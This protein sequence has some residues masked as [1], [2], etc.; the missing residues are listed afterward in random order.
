MFDQENK[1][2]HLTAHN[3]KQLTADQ[4][5]QHVTATSVTI[6]EPN[7]GVLNTEHLPATQQQ[8]TNAATEASSVQDNAA[9]NSSLSPI[10]FPN[11]L[12]P[13]AAGH[14]FYPAKYKGLVVYGRLYDKQIYS[15]SISSTQKIV[16][17]AL[18]DFCQSDFA[19]KHDGYTN[20]A[21]WA[22]ANRL[23]N[24][25]TSKQISR[26]IS[27][28]KDEGFIEVEY[29]G[30][31]GRWIK[32]NVTEK[33]AERF[34]PV[35]NLE[36]CHLSPAEII[37]L[38]LTS[39]YACFYARGIDCFALPERNVISISRR[40][41][42]E[43]AF[44]KN[45]FNLALRN[46]IKQNLI[47]IEEREGAANRGYF[48]DKFYTERYSHLFRVWYSS[49]AHELILKIA[50]HTIM[51][52]VD[53][54]IVR[55][56]RA[57]K[58]GVIGSQLN[59]LDVLPASKGFV[60][61]LNDK[62]FM[63]EDGQVKPITENLPYYE[64]SLQQHYVPRN[65]ELYPL[66][67]TIAE[68]QI[69]LNI[70]RRDFYTLSPRD[71]WAI[72]LLDATRSQTLADQTISA[73]SYST[74]QLKSLLIFGISSRPYIGHGWQNMLKKQVEQEVREAKDVT[75]DVDTT[76]EEQILNDYYQ[77]IMA[78]DE[79]FSDD[80]YSGSV[81]NE[82]SSSHYHSPSEDL[83]TT[84][85]NTHD[86]ASSDHA[87]HHANHSCAPTRVYRTKKGEGVYTKKGPGSNKKGGGVEQKKGTNK[88]EGE[89]V[90]ENVSVKNARVLHNTESNHHEL[91]YDLIP[92]VAYDPK[93][94]KRPDLD[95]AAQGSSVD[96]A[97]TRVLNEYLSIMI[98][99]PALFSQYGKMHDLTPT[100][101]ES[102]MDNTNIVV[103]DHTK[104][105]RYI[106]TNDESIFSRFQKM[107]SL[108][109][110][111][112]ST[113]GEY[114][115]PP[116]KLDHLIKDRPL[117]KTSYSPKF[118]KTPDLTPATL[119]GTTGTANTTAL[120]RVEGHDNDTTIQP[121]FDPQRRDNL[122]LAAIYC[123]KYD[124][125]YVMTPINDNLAA[126][127]INEPSN[128]NDL[129]SIASAKE[130]K[131]RSLAFLNE[132][133]YRALQPSRDRSM[134]Y[135]LTTSGNDYIVTTHN[136]IFKKDTNQS[137]ITYV[138]YQYEPSIL[139][140]PYPSKAI[141]TLYKNNNRTVNFSIHFCYTTIKA[142]D[143][144]LG[145]ENY[146]DKSERKPVRAQT[147]KK[148]A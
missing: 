90:K 68:P 17:S 145:I 27:A 65:N 33:E 117:S 87:A 107:L 122:T 12:S 42:N 136:T 58:I 16:L 112:Q 46:L 92:A 56:M 72:T 127:T 9:S 69:C 103:L 64:S 142:E 131:H 89:N 148:N 60:I 18:N 34:T 51:S 19:S 53:T 75:S 78:M 48:F 23:N 10:G 119:G 40:L 109:A 93:N 139:K 45:S 124:I 30:E 14:N 91:E 113:K 132:D 50:D 26:H 57:H 11:S 143:N 36:D 140:E 1:S 101:Q 66:E 88:N 25:F 43:Q 38:S 129:L 47:K 20:L 3:T 147:I 39:N 73:F 21:N 106:P 85:S 118:E 115:C 24:K 79:H 125:P 22:I 55:V 95:P 32:I 71:Q 123:L 135:S 100:T 84:T 120:D 141:T 49:K 110:A 35:V 121:T 94:K 97:S 144:R 116:L 96:N 80:F 83:P 130:D 128:D 98:S 7:A 4:Q 81:Y 37:L 74:E 77:E 59:P 134:L 108:N 133:T 62:E 138:C 41:I 111:G 28:L 126:I 104:E 82:S 105:Y 13:S 44:S 114:C 6:S 61:V 52:F 70:S 15:S 2:N 146:R 8:N 137:D 67:P 76:I 86:E 63:D 102:P 5:K 99:D 29:R 31:Q 54:P